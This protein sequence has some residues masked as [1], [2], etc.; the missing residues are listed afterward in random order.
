MIKKPISPEIRQQLI[1]AQREEITEYHIY[2]KLAEQTKDA[3]N[4]KVLTQIAN[5]ELKH[6]KLWGA[7]TNK[8]VSPSYWEIK[9]YYWIA[10]IFGL[11]F[12]LK[13]MEK[14]EEKAQINYALIAT[15][16]PEALEVANDENQHEKELLGLIQEEHLK[17]M[18]SIVLGLNDALVE[19]LGTLAG[20]TFALQNTKLVALAGII[21]G[22]AGA[23]SMSSSEYL[24]NRA[25]GKNDMAI[26]S[27]VFTGIAYIVAV[28]FL[29]APFLIFSSVFIGL[30]VALFDSILIVFLF[31]YYISVANDQPFR[32]R[33]LEMVVLS[34]VVGLI[35]FGLGYVVRIFFGIE[36]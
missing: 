16:V 22:I 15:E 23:L 10:K 18:G 13:L 28:I 2:S 4:R 25:E 11:T 32:K 5:D 1:F 3:E 6:Y 27:S 33:F 9:K 12:G 35:S 20:L 34:S 7:Y 26:K 31:T 8:E 14:G 24:S 19:I 17:Y 21:T 30:L 36:V 29:V